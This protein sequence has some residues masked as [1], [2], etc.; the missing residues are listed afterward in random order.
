MMSKSVKVSIHAVFTLA[1]T[2]FILIYQ[3]YVGTRTIISESGIRLYAEYFYD[4]I[5]DMI[6]IFLLFTLVLRIKISSYI[7]KLMIMKTAS[8][9]LGIYITH[10]IIRKA[11]KEIVGDKSIASM[12]IYF[13]STLIT[14]TIITWL[15]YKTRLRKY[16]LK[17]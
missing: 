6:W 3:N 17:I 12:L 7:I 11:V 8:L 1:M 15:I 14:A 13:I 5:F 16:L 2:V 9:T 10:P 4:S